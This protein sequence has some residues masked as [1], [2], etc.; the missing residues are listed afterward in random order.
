MK[1]SF[2]SNR[3]IPFLFL[4]ICLQGCV[5]TNPDLSTNPPPGGS[6]QPTVTAVGNAIDD[7]VSKTIGAG[8]GSLISSDGKAELIF[9]AGALSSNTEISIQAIGNTAPNAVGN[10]YRL[11]PEGI[12]FAQK[13][14]LKF[15]YT[16]GDLI[17]TMADLMGIAYQDSTGGWWR[18]KDFTNDTVNKII[19]APISHFSIWTAFDMLLISPSS[20][21][22]SVNKS[23]DLEVIVIESDDNELTDLGGGMSVAPIVRSA[24][25]TPIVWA[26]NGINNGNSVSGTISGTSFYAARFNAPSKIPPGSQ[27]PVNVSATVDANF[28]YKG[29]SFGKTVLISSLRIVDAELYRV[30][31]R[32]RDTVVNYDTDKLIVWDSV[33]MKITIKDGAV[34][35]SEITNFESRATPTQLI[36][37]HEA[38]YFIP[39]PVG[40]INIT[41]ATGTIGPNIFAT[42]PPD[43]LLALTFTETGLHD[44][45][46]KYVALDNGYTDFYGGDATPGYLRSWAFELDTDGV[47]S[48]DGSPLIGILDKVIDVNITLLKN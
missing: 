28:I 30:E 47:P 35:I 14:T 16:A 44:P 21:V 29:K 39:D 4:T 45:K 23:T 33:S 12:K 37:S 11:L 25:T 48:G 36:L 13:P 42:G 10:S 15:H 9:P 6:G 7:P 2:P 24:N 22:V 3:F 18:L 41:E 32:I 20:A 8:G 17:S 31:F 43:R 27:N 19:S 40:M 26:A 38:W 1:I 5:K 46:L 34:T